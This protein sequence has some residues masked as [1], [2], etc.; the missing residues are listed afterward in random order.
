MKAKQ[1]G[2]SNRRESRT[3]RKPHHPALRAVLFFLTL[4]LPPLLLFLF[5]PHS[6]A[7]P[8]ADG[9]RARAQP[10]NR[11]DPTLGRIHR[12]PRPGAGSRSTLTAWLLF[13]MPFLTGLQCYLITRAPLWMD[14][15]RAVLLCRRAVATKSKWRAP[16]GQL[17]PNASKK[18][19][20]R[21]SRSA[22]RSRHSS[23]PPPSRPHRTHAACENL[24]ILGQMAGIT[25]TGAL[26]I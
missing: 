25:L 10:R 3:R 15:G 16:S 11:R 2:K 19:A 21:K 4:F 13:R 6:H 8:A 9:L 17:R 14:G 18:H 1:A 5:S 22:T 24:V 20:R 12:T 23:P 7:Y 26:I